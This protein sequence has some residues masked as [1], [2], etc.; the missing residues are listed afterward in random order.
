MKFSVLNV[1]FDGPRLDILGSRKLRTKASK[2]G[3]TVK[4]IILL[5]LVSLSW[6]WLQI[7][8]DMLPIT[9]STNDKFLVALTSLTLKDPEL[10]K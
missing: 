8:T 7:G 4:V 6:K 5:L 9:A 3:T 10:P 1:D 2:S